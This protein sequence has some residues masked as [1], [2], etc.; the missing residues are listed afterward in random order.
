MLNAMAFGCIIMLLMIGII[1]TLP[2][3]MAYYAPYLPGERGETFMEG[4]GAMSIGS[5]LGMIR[6]LISV[7]LVYLI[8]KTSLV[9]CDKRLCPVFNLYFCCCLLGVGMPIFSTRVSQFFQIYY[10]ITLASFI[11]LYKRGVLKAAVVA[12]WTFGVVRY[13]TRDVTSWVDSNPN[14]HNRYYFYESYL[15]YYGIWE[16]PDQEVFTRRKAIADQEMNKLK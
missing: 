1:L 15:P 2:P 11:M 3:V 7:F 4:D 9:K 6:T 12:M 10:L 14:T 8:S 16:E 13:Y 5:I